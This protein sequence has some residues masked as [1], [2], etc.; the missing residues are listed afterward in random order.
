M[1]PIS[2]AV[3]LLLL[4]LLLPAVRGELSLRLSEILLL[5]GLGGGVWAFLRAGPVLLLLLLLLV[6]ECLGLVLLVLLVIAG[7]IKLLLVVVVVI[8]VEEGLAGFV[9][10]GH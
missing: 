3:A 4:Q 2:I 8:V 9:G 5:I 6:Q 1:I 10:D 7:R